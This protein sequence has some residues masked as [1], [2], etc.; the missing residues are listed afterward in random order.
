[1]KAGAVSPALCQERAF[2]SGEIVGFKESKPKSV[3][4]EM[5]VRV[6]VTESDKTAWLGQGPEFEMFS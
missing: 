5:S 4:E 1:M 2:V 6:G 3:Q